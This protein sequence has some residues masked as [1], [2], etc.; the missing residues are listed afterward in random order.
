MSIKISIKM[1]TLNY[2]IKTHKIGRTYSK[3]HFYILNK[4]LNSGRPMNELC[5]NC[6]V[7]VTETNEQRESLFYL[8]LSLQVGRYFNFYIKGSV[9]PFITIDDTRKVLNNALQNYKKDQ[10]QLKVE[11]LKKITLYDNNLKQQLKTIGQLK[12]ALLRI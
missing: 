10:W 12:L 8:S 1:T 9:I 2:E 3:P 6:F 11:K 4:G 5:P 7:V